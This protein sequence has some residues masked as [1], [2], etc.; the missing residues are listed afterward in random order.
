M[1]TI[2]EALRGI[3]SYPIP[4]RTINEVAERRGVDINE[5]TTLDILQSR[6]FNLSRADLLWWLS[7]APNVTQGGQ[8]Y[9]F[10]DEQRMRMR[11][12]AQQ[13]YDEMEEEGLPKTL[14]GYKGKRL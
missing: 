11:N 12:M 5:E 4:L 7:F 8:S 1:N 9:S 14:Y 2:L 10:S 3:N 6:E 13:I